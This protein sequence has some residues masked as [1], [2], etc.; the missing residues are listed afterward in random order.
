MLSNVGRYNQTPYES[1]SPFSASEA[2]SLLATTFAPAIK[3]AGNA[4]RRGLTDLS[5][6]QAQCE[7]GRFR[8]ASP[9]RDN[10]HS[11]QRMLLVD[12]V[13]SVDQDC[14]QRK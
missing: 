14:Q 10:A 1:L 12:P 9:D 8:N 3:V 4:E 13:L 11:L 5:A 7:D 6:V 2:S